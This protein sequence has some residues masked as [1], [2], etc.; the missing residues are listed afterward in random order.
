MGPL[1]CA[2]WFCQSQKNNVFSVWS[3]L[4][5]YLNGILSQTSWCW[6]RDHFLVLLFYMCGTDHL[7]RLI[8]LNLWNTYKSKLLSATLPNPSQA[9]LLGCF[10]ILGL[11][12]TQTE[13]KHIFKTMLLRPREHFDSNIYESVSLRILKTNSTAKVDKMLT[14]CSRLLRG[15]GYLLPL[16]VSRLHR[17]WQAREGCSPIWKEPEHWTP[18][19][20]RKPKRPLQHH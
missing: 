18:F 2:D 15:T 14:A 19:T 16:P 5:S 17:W 12:R 10:F 9:E 7:H 11:S 8:K 1:L 4:G 3:F 6:H 13:C 20:G